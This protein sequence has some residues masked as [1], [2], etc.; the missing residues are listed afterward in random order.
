MLKDTPNLPEKSIHWITILSGHISNF[1][2]QAPQFPVR[3]D[4][5]HHKPSI[6]LVIHWFMDYLMF[7]IWL[8]V[9]HQ[10][11]YGVLWCYL[12]LSTQKKTKVS[13]DG[14]L[15]Y[16]FLDSKWRS[17][18]TTGTGGGTGAGPGRRQGH[19]ATALQRQL[20]VYGGGEMPLGTPHGVHGVHV[21]WIPTWWQWESLSIDAEH[22]WN[23][24]DSHQY[25]SS[26]MADGWIWRG[27]SNHAYSFVG[28]SR[29][30][31]V[32]HDLLMVIVSCVNSTTHRQDKLIL[33]R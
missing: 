5:V 17:P 21:C 27:I 8:S 26:G 10:F 30:I 7:V 16:D 23:W 2:L 13:K 29:M 28:Y 32:F 3:K 6:L 12:W 31:R 24:F 22:F 19:S 9:I 1:G 20:C 4:S 15:V 14:V 25:K 18:E 11:G 33:L